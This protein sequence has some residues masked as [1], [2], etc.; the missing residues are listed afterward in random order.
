MTCSSNLL[1]YSY[2]PALNLTD[3]VEMKKVKQHNLTLSS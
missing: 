1:A 3:L 2:L